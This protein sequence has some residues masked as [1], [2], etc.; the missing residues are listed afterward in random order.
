MLIVQKY[1]VSTYKLKENFHL[2]KTLNL[3][4]KPIIAKFTRNMIIIINQNISYTK[5]IQH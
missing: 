3:H 2:N 5:Y 1:I 4:I